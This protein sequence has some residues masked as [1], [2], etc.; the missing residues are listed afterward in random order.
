MMRTWTSG[1]LSAE[2]GSGALTAVTAVQLLG[3]V[4]ASA[5]KPAATF[6]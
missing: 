2:A 6:V 4:V 5:K 3:P 1:W